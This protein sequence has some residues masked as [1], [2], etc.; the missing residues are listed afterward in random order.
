MKEQSI[1]NDSSTD[2]WERLPHDADHAEVWRAIS[3]RG[4]Y[5]MSSCQGSLR[6]SDQDFKTRFE[7]V[8]E[9]Y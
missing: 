5:S 2:R 6:P 1:N 4:D 9:P 7:T 3:W 8:T